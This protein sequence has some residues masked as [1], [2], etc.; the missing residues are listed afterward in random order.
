[1]TRRIRIFLEGKQ[2]FVFRNLCYKLLQIIALLFLLLRL[3]FLDGLALLFPLFFSL[4]FSLHKSLFFLALL[5]YMF[6][7][8]SNF[9]LDKV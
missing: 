8:I 6:L 2:L 1:M 9:Q 3:L 5:L 4:T 7:H